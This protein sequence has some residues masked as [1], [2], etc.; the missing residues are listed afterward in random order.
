MYV[1]MKS[2]CSPQLEEIQSVPTKR[3]TR[4]KLFEMHHIAAEKIGIVEKTKLEPAFEENIK[5]IENYR[6]AID[7]TLDG[8]ESILQGAPKVLIQNVNAVKLAYMPAFRYVDVN[9]L[10]KAFFVSCSDSQSILSALNCYLMPNALRNTV[11][12]L[13]EQGEKSVSIAEKLC[14]EYGCSSDC[15]TTWGSWYTKGPP[16]SGR[17]RIFLDNKKS[18]SKTTSDLNI[19]PVS[20]RRI[21]KCEL[22]T[23][24]Y[25]I[26]QVHMLME[27]LKL[28]LECRQSTR[29][30]TVRNSRQ[31]VRSG[32]QRSEKAS[33]NV[34]SN[35]PSSVMVCSEWLCR[36][37]K[38][39]VESGAV[40]AL[41]G[42][43]PYEMLSSACNKLKNYM[44]PIAQ[45]KIDH[46]ADSMKK[47]ADTE[48]RAQ[49]EGRM[50]IRNI[51]R[52][53]TVNNTQMKIDMERIKEALDAMDAARYEVKNSK[54]KEV[55]EEKGSIYLKCL[56]N[57]N[58]Q[59]ETI[60]TVVDDI[61]TTNYN[62]QKEIVKV[63]FKNYYKYRM[64]LQ[65]KETIL[66][67]DRV[68]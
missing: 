53:V 46:I 44:Q 21:V 7:G 65:L 34:R 67:M 15:E 58:D 36:P 19:G 54:T 24:S 13:Y 20:V 57:F 11:I 43:N 3:F 22:G 45:A 27:K 39:V 66:E 40:Q 63:S 32:H 10:L 42:Q 17:P 41:P 18:M 60:Q 33:V 50:A 14:H 30:T 25:K 38:K 56:K 62:H 35:F 47:I 48:R 28:N 8:L 52:F 68:L 2:I 1:E 31:L 37:N 4:Y 61:D 59:A 16:R 26:R 29:Y 64:G 55:L 49:K 9:V 5:K 51:R 6:L 23:Y 12:R